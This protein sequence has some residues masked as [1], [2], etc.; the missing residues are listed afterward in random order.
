[1]YRIAGLDPA[2]FAD[3]AALIAQGALRV[4]ATGKPGFPCRITLDDAESGETLLLLNHVSHDV[5][6][7][8]RSAYAIYVREGADRAA[9]FQDEIPPFLAHR[10]LGLRGFDANGMLRGAAVA[11]PG[12]AGTA[13]NT[14]LRQPDIAYVDLH[15]AGAGCFLARAVR[16][17]D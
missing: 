1:M 15:N 4:T 16:H 2:P 6:T 7:P 13:L 3:T 12:Q 14:L 10:T 9:A 5:E 8:F 17:D 11:P